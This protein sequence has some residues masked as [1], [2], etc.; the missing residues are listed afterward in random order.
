[1]DTDAICKGLN[2]MGAYQGVSGTIEYQHSG[3][4]VRSAVILQI[5]GRQTIFRKQVNPEH[6]NQ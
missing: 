1:V 4:P 2:T 5:K 3:D 6:A